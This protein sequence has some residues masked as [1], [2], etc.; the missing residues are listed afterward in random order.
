MTSIDLNADLGEGFGRRSLG[1]DDA[2]L[3]VVTSANV[4]YGGHAGDPS[5]MRR[6]HARSICVH[7][8]TAG[9][10]QLVAGVR[11]ALHGAG[12]AVEPFA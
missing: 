9:A 2:L 7:G 8:D 6:V 3:D 1:D 5:I 12:V 4:A 10:A 11:D